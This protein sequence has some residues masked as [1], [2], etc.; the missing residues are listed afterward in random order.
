L[1]AA[2]ITAGDDS[3]AFTQQSRKGRAPTTATAYE[4]GSDQQASQPLHLIAA[5]VIFVIIFV[6]AFLF[7]KVADQGG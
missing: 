2:A 6:A 7:T 3:G 1:N 4:T 5:L